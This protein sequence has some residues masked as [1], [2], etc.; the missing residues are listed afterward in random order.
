MGKFKVRRRNHDSILARLL[1]ITMNN[2]AI[3]DDWKKAIMVP[4]YE[5]EID[6]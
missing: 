4:I 5:W 1:D 3:P 6:R 2:D